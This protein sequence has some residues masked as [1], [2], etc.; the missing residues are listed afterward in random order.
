MFGFAGAL[1]KW[2]HATEN[3]KNE[4]VMITGSLRNITH[5]GAS[6]VDAIAVADSIAKVG[7]EKFG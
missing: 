1:A 6:F 2:H 4:T 3:V 5:K 7:K